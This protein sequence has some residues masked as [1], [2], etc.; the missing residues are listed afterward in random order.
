M[1][2]DA[3][4]GFEFI[5]DNAVEI[6][7]RAAAWFFF[8][9]YPKV[10]T[11]HA[12]TVYL[13]PIA[14]SNGRPIEAGKTYRLKVPNDIPAKQFWSLTMYDRATWAFVQ[15]PL[16][17]AGLGLF[18]MK[19]MKVNA[20]GSVDV[21]VGPKAPDGLESNWIPTMGKTPYLWLR[22][23]APE[24]PFWKKTFKVPDVELVQ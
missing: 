1:V 10:L 8:T 6:D 24:E 16:D 17:R 3:R 9:F 21:Y 18:N 11:E 20:D 15:N 13:A 19:D 7:R 5:D 23:Y 12:G 4:H 22:L 14:D 2:P